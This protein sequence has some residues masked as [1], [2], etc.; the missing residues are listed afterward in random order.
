[1]IAFFN[2]YINMNIK[3]ECVTKKQV[4]D[5]MQ[6][7]SAN[8]L[9]PIWDKDNHFQLEGNLSIVYRMSSGEFALVPNDLDINKYGLIIHSKECLEKMIQEDYFPLENH[10]KTIFEECSIQIQL[11]KEQK[12]FFEGDTIKV[13]DV[14]IDLNNFETMDKAL[15]TIILKKKKAV[16]LDFLNLGFA[17]GEFIIRTNNGF[18]WAFLKRYGTYNPY[19]TPIILSDN[20]EMIDVYSLVG[21]RVRGKFQSLNPVLEDIKSG[22]HLFDAKRLYYGNKIIRRSDK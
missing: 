5:I 17:F 3:A 15:N 2:T 16:P 6:Y 1:M 10:D 21:K 7:L 13:L 8:G 18:Q 4:K 14:I 11:F 19:L 20:N 22:K 12:N 9:D